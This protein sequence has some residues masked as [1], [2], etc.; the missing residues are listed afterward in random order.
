[1]KKLF[2]YVFFILFNSIL[3]FGLENRF[4]VGLS[5]YMDEINSKSKRIQDYILLDTS[6][7]ILTQPF[8]NLFAN[9]SVEIDIGI[10]PIIKVY[11]ISLNIKGYIE[12]DYSGFFFG[13]SP[14]CESN[15]GNLFLDNPFMNYA[16]GFLLG[17][18]QYINSY[19]DFEVKGILGFSV[20]D[21][22]N[23]IKT[24]VTTSICYRF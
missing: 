12:K 2:L 9:I 23:K 7:E 24:K 19:L 15:F 4:S 5:A 16:I 17:Y 6:Y 1:M 3:V 10:N 21:K 14:L 11:E 18:N 20:Y 22:L 13:I 8:N